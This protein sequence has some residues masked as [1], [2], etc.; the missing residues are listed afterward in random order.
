MSSFVS[1]IDIYKNLMCTHT[2]E[3]SDFIAYKEIF[4]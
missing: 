1:F 2:S 3:I 4:M